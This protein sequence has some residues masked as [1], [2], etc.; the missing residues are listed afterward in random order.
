MRLWTPVT[1]SEIYTVFNKG[2]EIEKPLCMIDYNHKVG[3]S[4]FEGPVAAH[5]HGREEKK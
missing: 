5:V 1:E 4:R 2:K 3:R